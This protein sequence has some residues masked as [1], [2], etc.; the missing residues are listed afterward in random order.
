LPKLRDDQRRSGADIALIV[1]Q[2]LPRHTDN[3][4]LVDGIWVSHPRYAIPLAVAL[5]QTLIEVQ[6]TRLVQQGQQTKTEQVYQYLTG[7]KF[8]QRVEAVI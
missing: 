8:R 2:T 3:F 4:D 7:I 5:R 1:S 6:S